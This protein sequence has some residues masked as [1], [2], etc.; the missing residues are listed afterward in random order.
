VTISWSGVGT[1]EVAED[2]L[3]SWTSV[4]GATSPYPITPVAA[5]KFYRLR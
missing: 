3:G 1:L 4:P 2:V 5:R